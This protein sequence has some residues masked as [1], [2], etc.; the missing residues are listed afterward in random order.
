MLYKKLTEGLSQIFGELLL[1]VNLGLAVSSNY[2]LN[3]VGEGSPLPHNQPREIFHSEK[4][5]ERVSLKSFPSGEGGLAKPIC[6]KGFDK[7][8][9][10]IIIK[11]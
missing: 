6:F 11:E 4:T 8:D 5:R 7:T 3:T 1:L 2:N 10:E 9:E